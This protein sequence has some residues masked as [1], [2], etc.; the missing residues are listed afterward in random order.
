M[1]VASF[2]EIPSDHSLWETVAVMSWG[3][4]GSLW[5]GLCGK[6]LRLQPIASKDQKPIDSHM[7]K[8]G[9]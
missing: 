3:H 1:T 6:E 8:L 4:S 2:L 5:R 9:N 7:S